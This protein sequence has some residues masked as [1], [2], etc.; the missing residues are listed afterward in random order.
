M[1]DTQLVHQPRGPGFRA[2]IRTRARDWNRQAS[3]LHAFGGRPLL[4]AALP[5]VAATGRP[6]HLAIDLDLSDPQ[7]AS[8]GIKTIARLAILAPYGIELA[9]GSTLA[10]RHLDG[11]RRL[12]LTG[13]LHGSLLDDVPELPQLPVELVP[14]SAAEAAVESVDEMPDGSAPLHQIGGHPV[15]M[16]IPMVLPRCPLSG[17]PMKHVASVASMRRFPL[18]THDITLGLPGDGMLHV[19]WSERASTSI[20]LVDSP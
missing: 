11:G 16:R 20:G 10:V 1:P 19:F 7:L 12:E 5:I 4:G 2:I 15:W 17:R 9:H 6:L 8:L 13:D 18:G 14:L 3:P